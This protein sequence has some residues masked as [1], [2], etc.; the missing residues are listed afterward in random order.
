MKGTN[1]FFMLFKKDNFQKSKW[2]KI[3]KKNYHPSIDKIIERI[4]GHKSKNEWLIKEWENFLKIKIPVKDKTVLEIG[5]GGGW[6]LAQMLDLGAKKVIGIEIEESII[7][8]SEEVFKRLELQNYEFHMID[9]NFFNFLPSRS[10]DMVIEIT[11]FQHILEEITLRY[12]KETSKILKKD[13]MMLSQFLLNDSNPVK[14]SSWR[15]EGHMVYSHNEVLE[16]AKES[17]LE[18]IRYGDYEWTDGRGSLWRV[19]L[20]KPIL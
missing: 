14:K 20:F 16:I 13:G 6:Y 15:K 4:N 1:I 19:Y 18:V 11:V 10:V 3:Q 7:E 5:C 9:E 12:M 2:R 17:D 8:K